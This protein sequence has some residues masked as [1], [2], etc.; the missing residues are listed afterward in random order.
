MRHTDLNRLAEREG[1]ILVYPELGHKFS[2][3]VTPHQS[4]LDARFIEELIKYLI[5]HENVEPR[6]IY[7][8]GFS[9]GADL[10][11]YFA[12]LDSL[13]LQI[14]AFAPVCSNLDVTWSRSVRHRHPISMIMVSGSDDRLNKWEGIAPRWLSV[15]ETFRFWCEHNKATIACL[16]TVPSLD[17]FLQIGRT[18]AVALR[19]EK[20]TA[21]QVELAQNAERGAEIVLVRVVGGGHTW[22]GT[23]GSNHVLRMIFG[24]THPHDSANDIMWSFFRRRM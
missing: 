22:P 9:S 5:E 13:A 15:P 10:L 12:G 23:K 14:S 19:T 21:L 11:H 3:D 8:T 7:A 16:S 4:A 24:R 20:S 1:V 2:L 6:Q 18:D 17:Q